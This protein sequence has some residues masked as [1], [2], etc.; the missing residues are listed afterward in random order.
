MKTCSNTA[1]MQQ[2]L[3]ASHASI[4]SMGGM[5]WLGLRVSVSRPYFVLQGRHK[6]VQAVP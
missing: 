2:P 4:C 5:G 6:S 3:T 1:S